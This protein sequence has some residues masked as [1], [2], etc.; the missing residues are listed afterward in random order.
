MLIHATTTAFGAAVAGDLAVVVEGELVVVG[1]LLARE[2]GAL[3][4]D[5]D[6]ARAGDGDE[7]RLA[8]GL[9]AVV[10][11]ARARARVR[12]VDDAAA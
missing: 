12:R 11:E 7:A 9:A 8:V 6:A 5:D 2:D 4:D 10:D 3:G 1:E